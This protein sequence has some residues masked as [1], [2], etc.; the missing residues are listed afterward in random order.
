MYINSAKQFS[1]SF[2][3]ILEN[4]VDLNQNCNYLNDYI[5]LKSIKKDK[6]AI[7]GLNG[8]GKTT[9]IKLLVNLFKPSKGEIYINGINL[10]SISFSS[11]IKKVSILFQDFKLFSLSV[12]ENIILQNSKDIDDKEIL[13]ILKLLSLDNKVLN[14]KN[15]FNTCLYK[16]FDCD[17]MELSGGES[18]KIAIARLIYNNRSVVILDE[19]TS[20][21]DPI[22]EMNIY[23]HFDELINNNSHNKIAIYISHRLSSC[24]FCNKIIVFDQGSIK[25][26][27]THKELLKNN[28]LYMNMWKSQA[29]YYKYYVND[30]NEVA[31]E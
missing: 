15:Q 30:K 31:Y 9:F 12:K 8:A 20:A 11:Y 25:E 29:K 26:T 6:I 18:Q 19:P 5:K 16:Y 3:L 7:V 10:D 27:G 13:R 24:K 1:T 4:L 28:S 17:G 14:S 2:N 23:K 22:S 21:L